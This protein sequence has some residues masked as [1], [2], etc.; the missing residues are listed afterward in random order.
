[1]SHSEA[2][3]YSSIQ[4]LEKQ[5]QL[6]RKALRTLLDEKGHRHDHKVGLSSMMGTSRSFV[7]SVTLRWAA[8]HI[9]LASQLPIFKG[10]RN[11]YGV[12][13]PNKQ[14]QDLIQQR[15]PDWR[16]QVPMTLYLAARKNHKFP[17]LLVV[18]TQKWVDDAQ[19][20][21]WNTDLAT[22]DSLRY[23]P[24]DSSGYFVDLALE[25]DSTL[26]AIDGQHRLMAIKGL[27]ELNDTGQLGA[28]QATGKPKATAP[29]TVDD[30]TDMTNG[31]IGVSEL[32][33][34]LSEHIGLELIPS[35]MMGETRTDALRRLRSIFVHVNRSAKPLTKGELAL[36]DEDNGFAVVARMTMVDHPLLEGR[37]RIKGGQLRESSPELT[38]L[39]TLQEMSSAY[40]KTNY[41]TWLP[42][43][44]TKLPTRPEEEELDNGHG[45]LSR[46]F[47]HLATLPSFDAVR[48]GAK[49][50]NYRKLDGHGHLLFRPIGQLALAGALGDLR[51]EGT[52]SMAQYWEKLRNADKKGGFR[53]DHE[54][55]PWY[56]VAWEPIGGKMRRRKSDRDLIQQLLSHVMGG[57]TEDDAAREALRRAFA[58]A[59]IVTPDSEKAV[60]LEGKEVELS[61][62][63]LP[64]PW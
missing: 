24:I 43:A 62:V 58:R 40:L 53:I 32:Q 21:Q 30:I 37:V 52:G 64:H 54:R 49:V 31:K 22:E 45:V 5:E 36:L 34:L 56:G 14:I 48:Q 28:R 46:F 61:K 7:T 12:I 11:E 13:E 55:L 47:D 29:I 57:G 20:D 6:K 15:N 26:Y 8:E 1:M 19:A 51:N 16:R 23:R 60:D 38:T 59:R 44:I 50:A 10:H 27:K 4:D 2:D 18:V 39:E 41:P 25:A 63:G 33:H 9:Q 3:V 17:P 35:V 42:H